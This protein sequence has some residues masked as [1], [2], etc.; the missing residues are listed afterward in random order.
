M[1]GLNAGEAQSNDFFEIGRVFA[2]ALNVGP[3]V[4]SNFSC[5]FN[6]LPGVTRPGA[7]ENLDADLCDKIGELFERHGDLRGRD[8]ERQFGSDAPPFLGRVSGIIDEDLPSH[9]T[10]SNG[11][12][13]GRPIACF[14]VEVD[15]YPAFDCDERFLKSGKVIRRDLRPAQIANMQRLKLCKRHLSHWAMA[16]GHAIDGDIV[17]QNVIAIDSAADI[18]FDIID[19]RDTRVFDGGQRV[20]MGTGVV[21]AMG[22]DGERMLRNRESGGDNEHWG[23][24]QVGLD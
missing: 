4:D 13:Y 21:A 10:V 19:S 1:I 16:I 20:F 11:F 14:E 24:E 23:E 12:G 5:S 6:H 15:I 18:E 17:H 7:V 22:D 9:A 2:G 8:D 3:S